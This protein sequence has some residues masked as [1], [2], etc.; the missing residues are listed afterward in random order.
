MLKISSFYLEKQKSCIPKKI[1]DLS[2]SL[3]IGQDS[4][5]K[6]CLLS[7]FSAT[8]LAHMMKVIQNFASRFKAEWFI[9]KVITVLGQDTDTKNVTLLQF[10]CLYTNLKPQN[11]IYTF[12]HK[13]IWTELIL[14]HLSYSRIYIYFE[15]NPTRAWENPRGFFLQRGSTT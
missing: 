5:N 6:W 1:Y 14:A 11:F 2:R 8:V 10:P 4:S 7:Q 13:V 3:Y 9:N 12:A 15:H